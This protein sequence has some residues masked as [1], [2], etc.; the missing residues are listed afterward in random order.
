MSAPTNIRPLRLCVAVTK[1]RTTTT[2]MAF[3]SLRGLKLKTDDE[4]YRLDTHVSGTAALAN[5]TSVSSLI[6]TFLRLSTTQHKVPVALLTETMPTAMPKRSIDD[7][8]AT[9]LMRYNWLYIKRSGR[10]FFF[11]MIQQR[12]FDM[13]ALSPKGRLVDQE[14]D[15]GIPVTMFEF[16]PEL[17]FGVLKRYLT[18]KFFP[19][20]SDDPSAHNGKQI[21]QIDF[22]TDD[23]ELSNHI[24]YIVNQGTFPD[25]GLMDYGL[26]YV[27]VHLQSN[28]GITT[29]GILRRDFPQGLELTLFAASFAQIGPEIK[30]CFSVDNK[31]DVYVYQHALE[32]KR[33]YEYKSEHWDTRLDTL[34]EYAANNHII[35]GHI[36]TVNDYICVVNEQPK[37]VNLDH[38]SFVILRPADEDTALTRSVTKARD[39]LTDLCQ[40]IN[41]ACYLMRKL[42]GMGDS[43]EMRID[44]I[45]SGRYGKVVFDVG[46]AH[47]QKLIHILQELIIHTNFDVWR[48]HI[49]TYSDRDYNRA[50]ISTLEKLSLTSLT[51]PLEITTTA[52]VDSF[53]TAYTELKGTMQ[54]PGVLTLVTAEKDED[55]FRHMQKSEW[56]VRPTQTSG[57][58]RIDTFLKLLKQ[59]KDT[60]GL[61]DA[62]NKMPQWRWDDMRRWRE[63]D[64]VFFSMIELTKDEQEKLSPIP[65]LAEPEDSLR[66]RV[67]VFKF[68]QEPNF[69][70][71]IP[72]FRDLDDYLTLKFMDAARTGKQTR[73]LDFGTK[74]GDIT[75]L[76]NAALDSKGSILMEHGASHVV[77]HR[78]TLGSFTSEMLFRLNIR[79]GLELTLYAAAFA[80][81]SPEIKLCFNVNDKFDVYVYEHELKHIRHY[82]YKT[83][84][85]ETEIDNLFNYAATKHMILGHILT[86]D[87]YM[88]VFKEK[89][90]VVNMEPTS[91]IMLDYMENPRTMESDPVATPEASVQTQEPDY[92]QQGVNLCKF[93]NIAC[94][95]SRKLM[96]I[97][98]SPQMQIDAIYSGRHARYRDRDDDVFSRALFHMKE[99][100]NKLQQLLERANFNAWNLQLALQH[101][102]AV[103]NTLG[104]QLPFKNPITKTSAEELVNRFRIAQE[105]VI[106]GQYP[107]HPGVGKL[108]QAEAD[109][110]KLSRSVDDDATP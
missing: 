3:P 23:I 50:L 73:R 14:L 72:N 67:M 65:Q 63:S 108:L 21:R 97:G 82:E 98:N 92:W 95:L 55:H 88:V 70:R 76:V 26:N 105:A 64:K 29:E 62:S 61:F 24:K 16:R 99:L 68:G 15:V 69:G 20:P 106:S 41:I 10:N 42:K 84:D 58:S 39:D 78:K 47:I 44:A 30:V 48:S 27:V 4:H 56:S 79:T 54:D 53:S 52:L 94:Y 107:T 33:H 35:L 7:N 11:S 109:E 90:K 75:N 9:V 17:D 34:F 22:G 28:L 38:T 43:P 60:A 74:D 101:N 2:N 31:F 59:N 96:G 110:D 91:I 51:T 81:I 80:N 12:N 25:Y 45:N 40:F 93:L 86:E 100:I 46:R 8:T 89:P 66:L 36:L 18:S 49:K 77:V 102:Q 71:P 103:I 1:E 5:Q 19:Q 104:T 37:F 6:D 57:S 32:H 13:S 83:M 87:N 85:W